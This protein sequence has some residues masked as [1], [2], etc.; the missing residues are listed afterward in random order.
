MRTAIQITVI[1]VVA[2][3]TACA[4]TP[5]ESPARQAT[6]IKANAEWNAKKDLNDAFIRKLNAK[7]AEWRNLFKPL[8]HPELEELRI[9]MASLLTDDELRMPWKSEYNPHDTLYWLNPRR[10]QQ[11]DK[12]R[13]SHHTPNCDVHGG[14]RN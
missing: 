4:I 9:T 6:R 10:T 5:K 7:Q 14:R 1:L 2:I 3:L 8:S 13:R 12:R 11:N